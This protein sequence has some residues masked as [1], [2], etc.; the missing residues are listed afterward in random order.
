MK[1]ASVLASALLKNGFTLV[2]GGTDTHLLLVDLR[3]AGMDGKT[4]E[5]ILEEGGITA[6]RNSIPGDIKPLYPSGLR[7]GT[8]AVTTRGMKEREMRMIAGW[9]RDLVLQGRNPREVKK[10]AEKLCK[11]FPLLY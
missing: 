1:N 8:P 9:I 5:G 3:S 2:S 10:E 6:N 7:L 4:V 11:K